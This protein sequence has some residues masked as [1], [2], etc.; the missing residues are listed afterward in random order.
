MAGSVIRA[1]PGALAEDVTSLVRGAGR[2]SAARRPR[3]PRR[4]VGVIAADSLL[5]WSNR[6]VIFACGL[7]GFVHDA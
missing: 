4:V 7:C 2:C 1:A 6:V 5:G 3:R